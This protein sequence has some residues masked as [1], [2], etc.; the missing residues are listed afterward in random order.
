MIAE[1]IERQRAGTA[2]EPLAAGTPGGHFVPDMENASGIP[3][4]KKD[5]DVFH[6]PVELDALKGK[7]R[8]YEE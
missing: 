8:A 1:E 6:Q 5:P 3:S 7:T 2:I 4:H